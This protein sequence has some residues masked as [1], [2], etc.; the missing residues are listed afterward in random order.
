MPRQVALLLCSL[1]VFYLLRYDRSNRGHFFRA[2]AS[3]FM[4][5]VHWVEA[6]RRLA[7]SRRWQST[8]RRYCRS[9]FS[10]RVV[11]C[12]FNRTFKTKIGMVC[13]HAG[14]YVAGRTGGVYA[15][16][17][18]LVRHAFY[19]LQAVDQ[20]IHGCCYGPACFN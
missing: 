11:I 7:L 20:G 10:E 17:R 16:K 2:M 13:S 4:D 6:T 12:W 1:F 14:K 3:Y 15:G 19:L 18:P 8:N 9:S 5:V